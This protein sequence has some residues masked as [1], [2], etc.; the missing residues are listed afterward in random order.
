MIDRRDHM[1]P[2]RGLGLP[3]RSWRPLP[4]PPSLEGAVPKRWQRT[5][6]LVTAGRYR[7]RPPQTPSHAPWRETTTLWS[8]R[9]KTSS[10]PSRWSCYWS[11]S[12]Y[13]AVATTCHVRPPPG[14]RDRVRPVRCATGKDGTS[15]WTSTIAAKSGRCAYVVRIRVEGAIGWGK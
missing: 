10:V 12:S 8:G 9:R 7:R 4:L 13:L 2:S 3:C 1:N 5:S 15:C 14:C 11:H 6:L